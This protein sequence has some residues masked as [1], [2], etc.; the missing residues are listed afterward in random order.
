M[1][2]RKRFYNG[3]PYNVVSYDNAIKEILELAAPSDAKT[4]IIFTPNVHHYYLYSKDNEFREAYEATTLSLLDGMPLVW[5]SKLF[6][7]TNV[8]KASGSDIF[9]HLFKEAMRLKLRVFLL[10]AAPGV[11]QKAVESLGAVESIGSLVFMDSPPKGFEKSKDKNDAVIKRI[12]EIN[13][14]I[15]FV[16]LGAPKQELWMYHNL[17]RLHARVAI[18]VGGSFDFA[19]GII[20]RA[21]LWVSRFGLEWL[22]RL[23]LEPKRLGKRYFVTNIFFLMETGKMIIGRLFNR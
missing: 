20:K 17:Q 22:F 2:Q 10:G 21:P 11:A 9:I 5:V 23:I 16:A 7:N 18:G 4:R 12:N 15:L 3:L 19:A 14:D 6:S 13:P 8:D 1:L